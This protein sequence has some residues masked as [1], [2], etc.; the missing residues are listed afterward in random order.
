MAAQVFA[1]LAVTGLGLLVML[2][3]LLKLCGW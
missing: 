3:G 1:I 2:Y